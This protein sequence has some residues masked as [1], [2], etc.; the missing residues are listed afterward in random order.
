MVILFSAL[1][2]TQDL[3]FSKAKAGFIM[4]FYGIGSIVGSYVGGWL[5]DRYSQKNIM[6]AS[7][8]SC[9]LILLNILYIN[10][11]WGL[12]SILFLYAL[13]ADSFRPSSTGYVSFFSTPENRTRSISLLRLA[14]NLGFTVG[15]AVGGIIAA[16]FGYSILY[17]LD[18]A[19]SIIA[20]IVLFY[21]LQ[22]HSKHE[23]KLSLKKE[24]TTRSAYK[25]Y[26][27][28][29][30]CIMVSV[31]GI[32]FFQLI[33]TVP[34]FFKEV[35]KYSEDTIGYLVGLNGALVVLLEMPLVA[36]LE[37]SKRL[38]TL[39]ALGC[40][41]IIIAYGFL[42]LSSGNIVSSVFYTLFITMSEILAMPFMMNYAL[43]RAPE[44]RQGQYSALYSISYGVSFIFAPMIGL[45]LAEH[46]GFRN[47][48]LFFMVAS[49]LL[50]I[51]FYWVMHR[52]DKKMP[53]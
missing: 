8:I 14:I 52:S 45:Y 12:M 23:N 11:E 48:F 43:S 42:V 53:A 10:N 50:S 21:A 26:P 36:K 47:M 9:S 13:T 27:Y 33:T 3:G 5:A 49:G 46:I 41:K 20:A 30:F 15:P 34:S 24:F 39:I 38:A 2:F 44:E 28:L 22:D 16:H 6:I 35:Y 29:L 1:Y 31:Y 17:I 7:L 32:C 19:T 18:A 4:S 37:K 40:I 51:G 25:D